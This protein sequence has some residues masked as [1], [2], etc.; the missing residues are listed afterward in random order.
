MSSVAVLGAGAGGL[1]SV[2]DLTHAGHEVRLWNRNSATLA[3]YNDGVVE[4]V[5]E[6][7]DGSVRAA[8]VTADLA[9]ATD[10][11]EVA[12]VCLPALAHAT[13]F[14]DLARIA[15]AIPVVLSPGHTGGALH[16][17]SVFAAR[18][19]P[20]PPVAELSTLPYI[21]RKETD[22]TVRVSG[23]ARQV[24]CG[25]LPRGD[26]AAKAAAELFPAA[27]E[28]PDVLAASLSNVNLVLHPPGA[29]LAAAWVE[30][31]G[32]EFT[33]YFDAMTP[34]VARVIDGLDSERRAVAARFGHELPTLI[35]EMALV[36]T[37]P[38]NLAAA[39]ETL[40]AIRAGEANRTIKAPG[41]L[42]HRY[43]LE[44][45]PFAL[46]PFLAFATVAGVEASLAR[47]LL[48][49]ASALVGPGLLVGGLD[50]SALG[51]A[52][53]DTDGLL[54]LVRG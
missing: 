44:D 25:A 32:G 49:V 52:A 54:R 29:V 5:G 4:H 28:V 36:G 38:A 23:K 31:T 11:A 46:L 40:A 24:R 26:E 33:F 42:R 20:L 48:E 10:G 14:A 13:V 17:R 27:V 3:P 8:L 47:A 1:S 35:E 9:A 41:S 34:G 37:A 53:L 51:I 50:A 15:C 45:F 22:G 16:M 19:C 6:L 30:A 18:G 12:V 21:A 43:Y 2:I 39:G 7:G